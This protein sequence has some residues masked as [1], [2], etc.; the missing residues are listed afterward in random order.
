MEK[1]S[2]DYL[3]ENQ[4]RH[5]WNVGKDDCIVQFVKRMTKGRVTPKILEIGS[6]YGVLSRKLSDFSKCFA[7][8]IS[9]E[10][11]RCG[12]YKPALCCDGGGLPFKNESF[13]IVIA[14]DVLEHL[15]DDI[16]C[17][18]E[19]S[20]VLM[21]GGDSL[22]LVPAFPFLWSDMDEQDCHY[23]RYTRTSLKSAL[24]SVT[25]LRIIRITYFNTFMFLP[26]ALIRITQR[27]LK[28]FNKNIETEGMSVPP[29]WF[30]I[31][32]KYIFVLEARLVFHCNFPFG[33]SLIS[34]IQKC[35]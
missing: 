4:E 34:I 5:W 7:T 16:H 35:K 27:L 9:F 33:V 31:I 26:I 25:V 23:R 22:I 18:K 10:V 11:I 6:S 8:D 12:G 19:I 20:R 1:K 21:P 15:A 3:L 14:V 2:Y 13:D 30:N 28:R 17:L 24:S 29:S 32:L